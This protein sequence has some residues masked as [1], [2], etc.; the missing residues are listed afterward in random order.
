[1]HIKDGPTA[2]ELQRIEA[3][4]P[5]TAAELRVV[6]AEIA[7]A[8]IDDMA[9]EFGRCL[10]R[11]AEAEKAEALREVRALTNSSAPAFLGDAA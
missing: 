7:I 9:T 6:D 10:L 11:R 1:M 3:Q 2:Q 5:L 8:R 4:A